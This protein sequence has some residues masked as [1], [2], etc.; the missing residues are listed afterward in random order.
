[1]I[2][3][4]RIDELIKKIKAAYKQEDWEVTHIEYDEIMKIIA[5]EYEPKLMKKLDILMEGADWWY[6]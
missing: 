2:D 5:E 6:A 3:N 4:K 1:M